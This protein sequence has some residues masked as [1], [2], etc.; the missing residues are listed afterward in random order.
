MLATQH[1][2]LCIHGAVVVDKATN[3]DFAGSIKRIRGIETT[4]DIIGFNEFLFDVRWFSFCFVATIFSKA[5]C[6]FAFF[7]CHWFGDFNHW[8]GAFLYP[9]RL[10]VNCRCRHDRDCHVD[11][12]S[13]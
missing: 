2:V 11:A 3:H 7:L 1:S 10:V 12:H 6:I 4:S 8:L 5:L 9:S 13:I